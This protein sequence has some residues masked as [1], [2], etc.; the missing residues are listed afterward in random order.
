MAEEKTF[1][2]IEK[3][4]EEK[5][6]KEEKEFLARSEIRTMKKDIA[7]L[8]ETEAT[9][10]RKK[11]AGMKTE[12]ELHKETEKQSQAQK[13]AMTRQIAE[14]EAQKRVGE[15]KKLREEREEKVAIAAKTEAEKEEKKAEGFKELLKETQT[16]EEAER[17]R[18]LARVEAQAEGKEVPPAP[19]PPPPP[20]AP[21]EKPSEE[22]KKP[23]PLQ[24]LK[25]IPKPAFRRPSF[26]RPTFAQK[27][28][29]RVVLTLLVLVIIG[30]IG[31]FWYW[32]LNVR[33]APAPEEEIP[34]EI[35]EEGV[36]ELVIPPALI[37][38]EA[39]QTLEFSLLGQILQ[40]DLDTKFTRLIIKDSVENKVFGLREF[41][42]AF[43]VKTPETFY[44][45]INNDFTL[46]IYSSRET[47]RLGFITTVAEVDL[48][49]L[50]KY[51]E[52]T[53]EQDFEILSVFLGKTSPT[54][55]P[56]FR[57]VSYKNTAFRYLSFPPQ[58]FGICWAITDG[59]F[60]FTFSG[61]SIIKTIDKIN[62]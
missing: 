59:Y 33:E 6:K 39:S 47:N 36:A 62:E 3:V 10:E 27:L 53:M 34:V 54:L 51:W 14:T 60:I 31:T 42:E 46:F 22:P 30:A 29:I 49:Y 25:K 28:W 20:T 40:E 56:Y 12:Q 4:A 15:V 21:P 19:T 17:K 9:Q 23:K 7:S 43:E 16:R 48:F 44:N 18:F 41:F 55:V 11:V 52:S 1:K 58:N 57:E 2:K 61:E 35:I 38:I 5:E 45:K 8:R 24:I 13:E 50:L 32:Y 26:G 37:S